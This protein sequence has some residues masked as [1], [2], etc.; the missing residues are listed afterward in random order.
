MNGGGRDEGCRIWGDLMAG[1][2][3]VSDWGRGGGWLGGDQ[4]CW[5][6]AR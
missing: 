4:G 3:R 2:G 1:F 5:I 6:G